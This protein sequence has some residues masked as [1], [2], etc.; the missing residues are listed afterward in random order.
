VRVIEQ[1]GAKSTIEFTREELEIVNNALNWVLN[2]PNAIEEWE[3]HTG[4]GVERADAL[5][6]LNEWHSYIEDGVR[7]TPRK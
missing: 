2:G 6:L 7:K 4:I 5:R 1:H 3:F